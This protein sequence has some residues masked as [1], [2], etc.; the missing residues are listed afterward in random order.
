MGRHNVANHY[1]GQLTEALKGKPYS[2]VLLEEVEKAHVEVIN[3][4]LQ[5]FDGGRLTDSRGRVIDAKHALF[6]MTSNL[7]ISRRLGLA[8][9]HTHDQDII[10]AVHSHFRPEL[11]NRM[12]EIDHFKP[13]AL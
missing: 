13:L 11:I 12:D 3:L 4:F 8:L 9:E 7:R 6:I 10:D 2:V 5:V 1:R